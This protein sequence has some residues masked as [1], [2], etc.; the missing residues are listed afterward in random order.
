MYKKAVNQIFKLSKQYGGKQ[1]HLQQVEFFFYADTEDKG[2]NLAISLSQLGYDVY[3]V[4][5]SGNKWSIIGATPLM[6]I[7]EA[8]LIEWG[9]AMYLL[10]DKMDV[11]FDG[12]GM[13]IENNIIAT[14]YR[15]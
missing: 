7:D 9:E 10:A 15:G 5:R 2:S 13:M 14:S 12:W 4:E 6:K 1:G 11:L 8:T 3:G